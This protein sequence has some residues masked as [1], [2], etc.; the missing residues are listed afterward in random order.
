MEKL[1]TIFIINSSHFKFVMNIV[2]NTNVVDFHWF[3]YFANKKHPIYDHVSLRLDTIGS[4]C[5]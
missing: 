3:T 1:H 5:T 2:K 4:Q